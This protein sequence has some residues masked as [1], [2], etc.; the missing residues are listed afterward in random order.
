MN[1]IMQTLLIPSLAIQRWIELAAATPM[2]VWM[3]GAIC[4]VGVASLW[5]YSIYKKKA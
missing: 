5:M 2:S 1:V 4:S 3:V